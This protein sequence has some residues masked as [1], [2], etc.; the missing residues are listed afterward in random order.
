MKNSKLSLKRLL[1]VL[2]TLA[3]C[4]GVGATDVEFDVKDGY[5]SQ[6]SSY[7]GQTVNVTLKNKTYTVGWDAYCFP[8]SADKASLDGAFGQ[9]NY[10]ILKYDRYDVDAGK[11]IFSELET[12]AVEAGKAYLIKIKAAI[13]GTPLFQN[14]SFASELKDGLFKISESNGIELRG[15]Y[16]RTYSY[17][18]YDSNNANSHF[19]IAQDGSLV[20]SLWLDPGFLGVYAYFYVKDYQT[21]NITPSIIGPVEYDVAQGGGNSG[22][23]G[24]S[25]GGGDTP[26]DQTTLAYKIANK[27]QLSNVPTI[28]LTIPDVANIDQDLRKYDDNN[29]ELP[30]LYHTAEITVVDGNEVAL[31]NFTDEVEIKVRGNSTA[32]ISTGKRPYRLKFPKKHKHD[33]M[34]GGY[35]KRNWTLLA[36]AYDKSL[37]RNAITYHLGEYVGL[38]FTA[39]YKFV[40]LVINGDYRGSYQVSDHIEADQNRVDVNEDTGWYLEYQGTRP[41][42]LDDPNLYYKQGLSG[43]VFTN[44]HSVN[45]KNPDCDDLT[46]EQVEDL[47]TKMNNW[48]DNW[49]EGFNGYHGTS[50]YGE[51]GWRAFNDLN[52]AVRYCIA[53]EITG[54]YDGFMTTKFYRED[55][56]TDKMHWGPIWDKDLAYGN[57]DQLTSNEQLI[58]NIGNSGT[59]GGFVKK[60]Y[61]D[62]YFVKRMKEVM[63][64]LVN[65]GITNQ[66]VADVEA[67]ACGLTQTRELDY[68]RWTDNVTKAD[69]KFGNELQFGLTDYGRYVELVK[70]WFTQRIPWLQAQITTL[71]N[72]VWGEDNIGSFTYD[73]TKNSGNNGFWENKDKLLNVTMSNKTFTANKWNALTL[74]FDVPEEQLTSVFGTGYELKEFS[75]VSKDGTK[76]IFLTPESNSVK[77]ATPYLI[78]PTKNVVNNPQFSNIILYFS[79]PQIIGKT[80]SFGN[81][82]F[83]GYMFADGIPGD[84]TVRTV[85]EDGSSLTAPE[86]LNSWDSTIAHDGAF[87]YIQVLNGADNPIISFE[88]EVEEPVIRTQLADVP[89]IYIDTQNGAVIQPSTGEYVP[90]AIEVLDKNNMIGG[91]FTETSSYLEVRGRGKTE[92]AVKDGKKSYR[93]KFAKDEKDADGNVTTSHKHDLTNGGY[94]KRNWILLA[95]A[96]DESLVRNAL[97]DELG[98][99]MGFAFTPKYQHVDLYINNVYQGTYLA[100]DHVEAD[101]ENGESKRVPVDEKQGWLLDMTNQDGIATGDVYV[102]GGEG[103]PFINI[104]NPE[105]G[106]KTGTEE[107]IRA[108]VK[109]FFDALW[110]AKDGSRLDK[111]SFVNWYIATEILGNAS[112]LNGIYAYKENDDAELK[113]GPLWGNELALG[114]STA[115]DMSDLETTGSYTGMVYKSATASAWQ[116]KLQTLWQQSWFKNAVKTRWAEL[117][118]GGENDLKATMLTKFAE[119]KTAVGK[120]HDGAK[121]NEITEIET[122]LNKRFEYLNTKFA[123]LTQTTAL[124]GDVN[125]DGSANVTDIMAIAQHIL[126]KTPAVF[127][128]VAADVDE[129]GS[130]NVNDIMKL[131]TIILE[132]E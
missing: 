98:L 84:G 16:F 102:E 23:G 41:D 93:L 13:T 119:V 129:N 25:G 99:A 51:N 43:E 131:V 39:G 124:I 46:E 94:A 45:I 85:N 114:N 62:P 79:S 5:A 90:A 57:C 58:A 123:E 97:A 115:I 100:T 1:F 59:I 116:T 38:P 20:K 75:A 87:A 122:Y 78:K 44:K 109:T 47:K 117:Y 37:L 104:K 113:F 92:W 3:V 108:K 126:G 15:F 86:K 69:G 40:D 42:M 12:P 127:D 10:V 30:N 121:A 68:E 14:V 107:A 118:C 7:L 35:T 11:F 6:Y 74:P 83:Q 60:M 22:S 52:T 105:P 72:N 120:S 50:V 31:E 82:A 80:V 19:T 132:K 67:I 71:Y 33:L 49:D 48:L 26:V 76:M 63:D 29:L 81:Y 70:Q 34:G 66:L 2:A 89:T 101:A 125:G 27:M 53:T 24:E 65:A 32:R 21:N 17:L 103:Y 91:G 8:F 96:A 9:D 55:N 56:E 128:T 36:N 88:A 73:V 111:E 130:I 28:Y 4:S 54:D 77:A 106:S 18:M 61:A 64:S 95:N 110:A 112:A